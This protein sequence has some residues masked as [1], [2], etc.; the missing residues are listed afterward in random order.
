M[1]VL[2]SEHYPYPVNPLILQILIL[3]GKTMQNPANCYRHKINTTQNCLNNQAGIAQAGT[4]EEM[5]GPPARI[6]LSKTVT[7]FRNQR[8]AYMLFL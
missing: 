8:E 1:G 2:L 7:F 5:R 3:I 6:V 4:S